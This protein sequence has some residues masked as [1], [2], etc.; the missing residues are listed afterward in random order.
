MNSAGF[1]SQSKQRQPGGSGWQTLKTQVKYLTA[2]LLASSQPITS[3]AGGGGESRILMTA[4]TAELQKRFL[5]SHLCSGGIICM[6]AGM[7]RRLVKVAAAH[8]LQ[9]EMLAQ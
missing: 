3:R 6:K 4:I 2:S 9:S 5:W 7:K 1:I 8:P